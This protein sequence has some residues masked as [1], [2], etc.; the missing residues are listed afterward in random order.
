MVAAGKGAES[1]VVNMCATTNC[2]ADV[3]VLLRLDCPRELKAH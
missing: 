2:I 3:V 1:C